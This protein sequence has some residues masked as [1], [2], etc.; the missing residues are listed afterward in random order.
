[1]GEFELYIQRQ[2]KSYKFYGINNQGVKPI[3]Q[4]KQDCFFKSLSISLGVGPNALK[5]VTK[6]EWLETG[7]PYEE[8]DG[9]I[10]GIEKESKIYTPTFKIGKLTWDELR[11]K[12]GEAVKALKFP[13]ALFGGTHVVVVYAATIDSEDLYS[14]YLYLWDPN[15]AEMKAESTMAIGLGYNPG[16]LLFRED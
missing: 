3:P 10:E 1:M 4:K 13:L 9:Y 2:E 8:A 11:E 7:L 5:A 16:F 14:G 15:D 6:E 12:D